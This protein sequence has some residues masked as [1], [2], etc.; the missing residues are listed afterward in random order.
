MIL[1][2]AFGWQF[3]F[4]E[5]MDGVFALIGILVV[6]FL[7]Q[8]YTKITG[9]SDK[10]IIHEM[11]HN[12]TDKKVES[13]DADLEKVKDKVNTHEVLLSKI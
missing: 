9:M 13:I 12:A 4:D 5:F 10:L 2:E 11:R 1:I 7:K 3:T 6:W 8:I